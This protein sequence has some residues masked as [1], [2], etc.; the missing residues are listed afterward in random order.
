MPARAPHSMVMLRRN[1]KHLARNP[2]SVFNAVLMPINTG[3]VTGAEAIRVMGMAEVFA[4]QL[5]PGHELLSADGSPIIVRA[6][7]NHVGNESMR[8]LTVANVHTYYVVTADVPVLV[9]NCDDEIEVYRRNR[10]IL[11]TALEKSFV[12]GGPARVTWNSPE[13]GYFVVMSVPSPSTWI[14]P[15]SKMNEAS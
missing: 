7:R 14:A 11:L 9:H 10:R 12:D 8:D 13:G 4:A 2:T 3:H 5:V 1:F 15:P 6:V